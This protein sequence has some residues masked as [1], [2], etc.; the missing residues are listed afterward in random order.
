MARRKKRPTHTCDGCKGK[1]G[2][3]R[4]RKLRNYHFCPRCHAKLFQPSEV[5]RR[6]KELVGGIP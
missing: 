3:N 5:R 2:P 4:V 1:V 6:F